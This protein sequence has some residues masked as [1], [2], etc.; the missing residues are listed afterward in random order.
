MI[1]PLC[2]II[3]TELLLLLRRSQEWLY[4]LGFFVIVISLFPIALSPDPIFLQKFI[5]GCIWIAALLANF[6][7]IENV[8]FNEL[9]D[10]NLEQLL[11]SPIPLAISI[12]AKLFARWLITQL[13]L[14]FLARP[15]ISAT[16]ASTAL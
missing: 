6:L 13:P 4:P 10:G 15:L 2:Y 5:P 14:I 9:E 16:A 3:Y 1:K 8:F 7:S 11:L 12:L